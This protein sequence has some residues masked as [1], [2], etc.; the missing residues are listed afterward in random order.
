MIEEANYLIAITE[1]YE[2]LNNFNEEDLKKIPK[3]FMDFLDAKRIKGYVT[4]FDYSRPLEELPLKLESKVLLGIIYKT[5]WCNEKEREE[6][7]KVLKENSIKMK[8]K[9]ND[10]FE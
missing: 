8:K 10:N 1:V 3:S 5:Y 4:K 2:I 9:L 7:D 6:F